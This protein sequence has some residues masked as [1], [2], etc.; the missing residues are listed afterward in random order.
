MIRCVRLGRLKDAEDRLRPTR[1]L[2]TP[3]E[4]R[5]AVTNGIS[6]NLGAKGTFAM[7]RLLVQFIP[8]TRNCWRDKEGPEA[9][10]LY[11]SLFM[12]YED[13][14]LLLLQTCP[15]SSRRTFAEIAFVMASELALPKVVEALVL[16]SADRSSELQEPEAEE[17]DKDLPKFDPWTLRHGVVKRDEEGICKHTTT[18]WPVVLAAS[19]PKEAE[20]VAVVGMLIRAMGRASALQYSCDEDNHAILDNAVYH[21]RVDIVRLLVED[22]GADPSGRGHGSPEPPLF[23]AV[24]RGH[25]PLVQ[26]L[27]KAQRVS[28]DTRFGEGLTERQKEAI[29]QRRGSS[30][31]LGLTPLLAAAGFAKGMEENLLAI[32]RWLVGEA[33]ADAKVCD[34]EGRTAAELAGRVVECYL[35]REEKEEQAAAAASALLAEL[36]MGDEVEGEGKKKSKKARKKEKRRDEEVERERKRQRE[37]E[38]Q[39]REKQEEE[40]KT[41]RQQAQNRKRGAG[42][43]R[44]KSSRGRRRK[45]INETRDSTAS[46]RTASS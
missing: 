44:K 22:F 15:I 20:A 28:V 8:K 11:L 27:M 10:L 23:L 1:V 26:Y 42:R 30:S 24:L 12:R 5:R 21:G 18:T 13:V 2:G 33:G 46:C 9:R 38:E 6:Y 16:F 43:G 34:E 37:K 7:V 17:D 14:T 4:V 45:G 19:N 31:L 40:D 35:R 25:L 39:E 3:D 36:Q 32:V 29:R 41:K